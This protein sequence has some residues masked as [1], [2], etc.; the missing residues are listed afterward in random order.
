M[1]ESLK[2]IES[3]VVAI[4][5]GLVVLGDIPRID[6]SYGRLHKWILREK[7][8]EIMHYGSCGNHSHVPKGK[9]VIYCEYEKIPYDISA[10]T[11]KSVSAHVHMVQGNMTSVGY[12]NNLTFEEFEQHI[13]EVFATGDMYNYYSVSPYSIPLLKPATNAEF[14]F[15]E[16]QGRV[17]DKVTWITEPCSGRGRTAI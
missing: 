11:G 12:M 8:E 2:E 9:V 1:I 10:E 6:V 7:F 14:S 13:T 4:K 5:K 17:G 3:I 16:I 15:A